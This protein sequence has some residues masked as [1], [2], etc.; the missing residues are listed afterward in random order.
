MNIFGGVAPS[1]GSGTIQFKGFRAHINGDYTV[2]NNGNH[3]II[4]F[5][6]EIYDVDGLWNNSTYRL[7]ANVDGYYYLKAYCH[8]T[9]WTSTKLTSL[10]VFKNN[11]T[12]V[13]RRVSGNPSADMPLTIETEQY[14]TA[15]QY[16]DV[17]I[18]CDGGSIVLTGTGGGAGST[19]NISGHFIGE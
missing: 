5:A 13:E 7:T 14:L 1:A 6:T 9:N 18:L 4:P 16:L 12:I 11:A 19:T 3:N 17:R 8:I 15:G 2:P 10:Y